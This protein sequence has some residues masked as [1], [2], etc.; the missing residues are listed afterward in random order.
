MGQ[1]FLTLILSNTAR[2]KIFEKIQE[3][4]FLPLLALGVK[5]ST[6]KN[7]RKDLIFG[8]RSYFY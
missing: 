5:Q 1:D 7:R 6:P 2:Y 8:V 3:I 4:V